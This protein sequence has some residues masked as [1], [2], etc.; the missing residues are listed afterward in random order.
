MSDDKNLTDIELVDAEPEDGVG[1]GRD[2]S[3]PEDL[4][5]LGDD[6]G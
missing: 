5:D 4:T 3:L 6:H 2:L 1:T